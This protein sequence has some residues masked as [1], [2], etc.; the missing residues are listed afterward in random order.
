MRY[1]MGR[2]FKWIG[3]L[4]WLAVFLPVIIF[5]IAIGVLADQPDEEEL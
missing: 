1:A 2:L 5:S 4:C 3:K